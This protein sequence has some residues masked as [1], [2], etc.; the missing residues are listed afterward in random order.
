MDDG[1]AMTAARAKIAIPR[2]SGLAE[3]LPRPQPGNG[4]RTARSKPHYRPLFASQVISAGRLAAMVCAG[5]RDH[6]CPVA[7]RRAVILAPP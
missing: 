4:H 3:E 1:A 2:L 5:G 7:S 6:R